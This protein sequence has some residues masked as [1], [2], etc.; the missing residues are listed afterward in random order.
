MNYQNIY[1]HIVNLKQQNNVYVTVHIPYI[2]MS[3]RQGDTN[4][5]CIQ[6]AWTI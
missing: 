1:L 4:K 3:A 2:F 6:L 5:Q